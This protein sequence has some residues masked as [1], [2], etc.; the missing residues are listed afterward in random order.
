MFGMR[1]VLRDRQTTKRVALGLGAVACLTAV[2]LG[3]CPPTGTDGT[4]TPTGSTNDPTTT[5][6]PPAIPPLLNIVATA[7]TLQF[8]GAGV[9]GTSTLSVDVLNASATGVTFNWTIT[10][11]AFL[12][13]GDA[14]ST[15][16][17]ATGRTVAVSATGNP[18]QAG[19]VTHTVTVT[20]TVTDSNGDPQ[21]V[22]DDINITVTPARTAGESTTLQAIVTASPAEGVDANGQI[23]LTAEALGVVGAA[24]FQWAV[25]G[26]ATGPFTA[27]GATDADT[28]TVT[29]AAGTRGVFRFQVVVTD[30][31]GNQTTGF[32]DVTIGDVVTLALEPSAG[33]VR[34]GQSFSLRTARNG[35]Q[36]S[37]S[38]AFS[39]ID[40]AGNEVALTV[41]APSNGTDAAQNDWVVSGIPNDGTFRIFARVTDGVGHAFS[42]STTVLVTDW[43]SVAVEPAETSVAPGQAFTLL[44]RRTGGA[45]SNFPNNTFSYSFRTVDSAGNVD[46]SPDITTADDTDAEEI[47]W[48]VPAFAATGT[49]RIYVTLAAAGREFVNSTAVA[50]G[51]QFGL[52]LRASQ[53]VLAPGDQISIRFEIVGGVGTLTYAFDGVAGSGGGA[54][55]NFGTVSPV[56]GT[57]DLVVTWTAPTGAGV[58][59]SYRIDGSVTDATGTVVEDS[60]WVD[61]RSDAPLGVDLRVNSAG[62]NRNLVLLPG[63]QL[64]LQ[65]VASGGTAPYTFAYSAIAPTGGTDAGSFSGTAATT[66]WTA[67]G[68][69]TF[70]EGGYTLIVTVTDSLGDTVTD[71]VWAYV[72]LADALGVDVLADALVLRT[73][74]TGNATTLRFTAT[75]GRAPYVLAGPTAQTGGIVT[76]SSINFNTTT[77]VGTA[78]VTATGTDGSTFIAVTVT[79]ARGDVFVDSCPIAVRLFD[80][81]SLNVNADDVV[82][83]T[84]GTGNATTLRFNATG[85]F[86]PYTLTASPSGCAGVIGISNVNFNTTTGVGTATLTATGVEDSCFISVTV[87]DARGDAMTDSAGIV[88]RPINAMS[89]DVSADDV[90]LNTSGSGNA[91]TLRFNATG[92]LTPYTLTASPSGCAG[93]IGISN[94]NFD[95]NTGVGTATLTATGVEDSCFIS[96]TVTDARGDAMTDTAGIVVRPINALSLDV[97]ADE[98]ILRPSGTGNATTLRFNATGG[99]TPYVLTTNPPTTS[100][101][102]VV[103]VSGTAFDTG[104]GVGTATLTATGVLDS[105]IVTVTVTD[106]RG[107]AFTDTV[108]VTVQAPP[109]EVDLDSDLAWVVPGVPIQLTT[110][111]AGG[112]PNYTYTFT[113]TDHQGVTGASVGVFDVSNVT[114]A[115]TTFSNVFVPELTQSGTIRIDVTVSD[116]QS[117]PATPVTCTFHLLVSDEPIVVA[118]VLINPPA[119]QTD[120]SAVVGGVE[121][122]ETI[123]AVGSPFTI[124]AVDLNVSDLSSIGARNLVVRINDPGGNAI[125]VANVQL[126]GVSNRGANISVDLVAPA[127]N[128]NVA[129][130][131]LFRSITSVVVTYGD[132]GDGD[133]TVEIGFGDR[134]GLTQKFPSGSAA[135]ARKAF[136]QVVLGTAFS[137]AAITN[138]ATGTFLDAT[139]AGVLAITEND[140]GNNQFIFFPDAASD[141][142]G[143]NDYVIQYEPE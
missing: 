44:T 42:A 27:V 87:T 141:P 38:Y 4:G 15:A 103:T 136:Q 111:V 130:S 23:T 122:G 94:V 63:G 18:G 49:Q 41:G 54:A 21:N 29:V 135:A 68:L 120:L 51:A 16:Q 36:A 107:D 142:D 128:T 77:G 67:P 129:T 74:G 64:D 133:E 14:T 143:V 48:S 98:T 53:N 43:V 65:S 1:S 40:A 30:T 5:P 108:V 132:D 11:G 19:N 117:P 116:S 2:L 119:A 123:P 79:D 22:T 58:D 137:A 3:G 6:T 60:V 13:F 99:L 82:L 140:S 104:T 83:N 39:A 100:P 115:G 37:F 89:L 72:R 112:S 81:M 134:I 93:V 139:D 12:A 70:V 114:Q 45:A 17:T 20:A 56:T 125:T 35:G 96:V 88:V 86:T 62:T 102:G 32:L 90:V 124:N 7:T 109:L 76:I 46:T 61:V 55:D 92:G 80:P 138:R 127:N 91:T 47:T 121:N 10:G 78:T 101:G 73:S 25:P 85:G 131:S 31:G 105:T 28:L 66:T 75:G 118:E 57:G 34:P 69:G 50:V 26:G 84:S 9:P 59:G 33:T 8:G 110:T 71:S 97:S 24:A 106:A 113:A 52:D 126:N 95:V